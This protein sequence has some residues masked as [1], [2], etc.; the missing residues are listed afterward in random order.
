[1]SRPHPPLQSEHVLIAYTQGLFPMGGDD[2]RIHWYSPD[3]R[4][5]FELDRLKIS[6]SLRQPVIRQLAAYARTQFSH[7][8]AEFASVAA[9]GYRPARPRRSIVFR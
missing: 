9:A 5:I 4:G 1:M 7:A 2:G 6:R 3:P 8:A